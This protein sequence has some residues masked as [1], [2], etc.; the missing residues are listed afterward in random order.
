MIAFLVSL[1]L[2]IGG[3]YLM[4]MA[5]TVEGLESVLFIAG[6]LITSLGIVIPVHVLKRVDG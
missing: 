3:L 1:A 6:I 2:F 4:G 5:F